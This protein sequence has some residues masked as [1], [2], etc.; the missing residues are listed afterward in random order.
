MDVLACQNTKTDE[1]EDGE[2]TVNIYLIDDVQQVR[3]L[4]I[5]IKCVPERLQICL[6]ILIG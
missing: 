4:P 1:S 3:S 5:A 6:S 2:V